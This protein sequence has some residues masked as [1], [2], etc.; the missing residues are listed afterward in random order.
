M[1]C[2]FDAFCLAA[3]R[4]AEE[5]IEKSDVLSV[6][7]LPPAPPSRFLLQFRVPYL[8]RTIRHTIEVAPG[9]VE[10]IVH[11]PADYL[12]GT[13]PQLWFRVISITT[14]GFVH[15]NVRDGVV[16]LGAQ[17]T[18]GTPLRILI[19]TLYDLVT[20][21]TMTLDE[22]NAMDP[23]ICR[24]LRADPQILHSL[25]A[26]PLTRRTHRVTIKEAGVR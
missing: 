11:F 24:L 20:Y 17:F 3:Q 14:A 1:D 7:A 22:R 13:T 2:V 4:E 19:R 9:P 25:S 21:H 16:C 10:A 6:R 23:E 12:L 18:P 8:R 26:P 15:P 5:L